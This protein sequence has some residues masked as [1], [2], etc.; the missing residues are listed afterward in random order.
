[1]FPLRDINPSR[2]APV[3]TLILIAVNVAVFLLEISLPPEKLTAA[4]NI[5]GIVPARYFGAAPAAGL[6]HLLPLPL[7]TS[8]F[9][10]AGWIHL[11][12][13][14]WILW[15]FGDNVEDRL[16]HLRFLV[17]Y[18]GSG[19]V[20]GLVHLF[21]NAGSSLPSIG[22]S[23]AIAGVMGA[24]LL[25]FPRA[26]V[27][28]VIPI[29][30][31]PFFLEVPAVVFMGFWFIGQFLSGLLSLGDTGGGIAWWAHVGGFVAGV[32]LCPVF[33]KRRRSR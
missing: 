12:S 30:I 32:L 8:M 1:V 23:G 22:A 5:Y 2:R 19:V 27:L 20:A 31:F 13:N 28:A 10:H 33:L 26:R 15:I 24:Y 9:L 25:L 21:T 16:G 4:M 29:F 7:L 6:A 11:I 14:L 18:L 3:M 17:F